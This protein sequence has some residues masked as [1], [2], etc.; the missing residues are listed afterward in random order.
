MSVI[1]RDSECRQSVQTVAFH[2]DDIAAEADQQLA[3]AR[4]LAAGAELIVGRPHEEAYGRRVLRQ[5]ESPPDVSIILQAVRIGDVG[6]A[7]IPFE[8][9]AEIGLELKE[10]SP[11][12]PTFTIELA[13]G[14]YG[15]LPTPKQ[16]ALGGYETWLG[17]CKVEVDSST[18]ITANLLE[19][20]G[21]LK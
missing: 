20:F 11:L 18:K 6:I 3:R 17:S 1:L 4:E 10:K 5:Q 16:H 7:A 2:F 21:E 8:P 13:N 19:M 14:A 12:K 15:Y 9:F